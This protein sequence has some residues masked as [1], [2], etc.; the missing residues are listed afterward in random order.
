MKISPV[1]ASVSPESVSQSPQSIRNIKMN[2]NRTPEMQYSPE[3]APPEGS[4]PSETHNSEA[5]PTVEAT[6]PI[7]PQFAA[8]AKQ[9]RALQQERRA[10]EDAKKDFEMS[11]QGSDVVSLADLKSD[12]LGV[13]LNKAGHTWDDLAGFVTS[14]Q[15]SPETRE[16]R[17]KLNSLEENFTKKLSEQ[18]SQAQ[19]LERQAKQRE[20][21]WILQNDQEGKYEFLKDSGKASQ[22]IE[23]QKR[24]KAEEGKDE[25]LAS[26]LQQIEDVLYEEFQ[27]KA[28]LKKVQSMFAEQVPQQAPARPGMRTLSNKDTSSVPM[29]AKQRAIA[30]F[31][32]TL[33]K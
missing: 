31:Y 24:I 10:F 4:G 33:K 16:L 3:L 22:A 20:I 15:S 11:K 28:K 13:L 18:E 17:T 29:T 26:C 8:L 7:S 30:A 23:L 27:R 19:K 21:D 5:K 9:R 32:G 2:V 25:P 12:P 14:Y 6:Q 1:P